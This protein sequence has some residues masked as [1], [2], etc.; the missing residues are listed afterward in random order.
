MS[1]LE[2]YQAADFAQ[3][4]RRVAVKDTRRVLRQRQ[5]G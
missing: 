3:S 5:R 4:M 2:N 1:E